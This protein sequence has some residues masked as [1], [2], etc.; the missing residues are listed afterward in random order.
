ML[1]T[2][3]R[4]SGKATGVGYILDRPLSE[5]KDLA[6]EVVCVTNLSIFLSQCE[7]LCFL[8]KV[9]G[10]GRDMRETESQRMRKLKNIPT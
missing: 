3:Y 10:E 2:K 8:Q 7:E 6:G 1:K 9:L 5:K 4:L